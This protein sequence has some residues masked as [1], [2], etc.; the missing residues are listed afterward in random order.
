MEPG[1]VGGL[2]VGDGV[3]DADKEGLG[4]VRGG[5]IVKQGVVILESQ[6]TGEVNDLLVTATASFVVVAKSGG[7]GRGNG[8]GHWYRWLERHEP[9]ESA[10]FGKQLFPQSFQPLRL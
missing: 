6:R 9:T 4:A 7:F 10:Q 8:C 1:A 5:A 2:F 3:A